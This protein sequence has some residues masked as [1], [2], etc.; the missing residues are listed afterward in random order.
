MA[1][2]GADALET[3]SPGRLPIGEA[4]CLKAP[5]A[6]A[7]CIHFLSIRHTLYR[8][9]SLEI[10]ALSFSIQRR[11]LWKLFK[12]AVQQGRS[13]R[14]T[15]AYSEYVEVLSEARTTP[16]SRRVLAR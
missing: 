1:G 6:D 5:H 7:R 13:E 10:R 15:E 16:G 3:L 11:G 14:M 2:Y 9:V 4:N 8:A 12:T